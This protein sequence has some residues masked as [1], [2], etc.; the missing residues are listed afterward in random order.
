MRR[1]LQFH[2][3]P[4]PEEHLWSEWRT[5]SKTEYYRTCVHPNCSASERKPVPKA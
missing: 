2:G 4:K 5:F 3:W 1:I